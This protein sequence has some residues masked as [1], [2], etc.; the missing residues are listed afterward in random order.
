M[1]IALER[2]AQ[3]CL[4]TTLLFLNGQVIDGRSARDGAVT[5]EGLQ[6]GSYEL[7][8]KE[9]SRRENAWNQIEEPPLQTMFEDSVMLRLE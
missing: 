7:V 9:S 2:E 5:I 6:T 8:V 1:R 3:S 4:F